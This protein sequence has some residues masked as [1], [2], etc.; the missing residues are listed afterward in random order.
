M[1][2]AHTDHRQG[3]ILMTIAML[4]LPTIDVLAKLLGTTGMSPGQVV[5]FRFFVQTLM[6]T[7]LILYWRLWRPHPGTVILQSARGVLLAVAVLHFF[8]AINHLPIAVAISIFFIEPMILTLLSA[9]ILRE[10]L[11]MRRI[12]AIIV[13]FIGALIIIRPSFE[14]VGTPALLPLVSAF[15]F[16][17]YLLLTR[18]LS[19]TVNPYQ[20]QWMVGIAAM[21]VMVPLLVVGQFIGFEPLEP[22][23]PSVPRA[24]LWVLGIGLVSTFGHLTIVFALSRAPASLLA[25]FQYLEI[26]GATLFGFLIF[27]NVPDSATIAGVTL[28]VGSGLYVFHREAVLAR[29]PEDDEE[30]FQPVKRFLN[31]VRSR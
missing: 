25:P 26:I 19:S 28:I 29:E 16:A 27:G 22:S 31:I 7:P 30:P 18:R 6:F 4:G 12:L 17:G 13:G 9:L 2:H 1:T 5:W 23:L 8:A 14:A 20:M 10:T 11:R 21:T 15:C 3:M 24:W